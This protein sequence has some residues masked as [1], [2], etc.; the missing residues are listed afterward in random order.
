MTLTL[1]HH[2]LTHVCWWRSYRT[3]ICSFTHGSAA[4]LEIYGGKVV[5]V[6]VT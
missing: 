3:L 4:V 1:T 6:A 5:C 2:I